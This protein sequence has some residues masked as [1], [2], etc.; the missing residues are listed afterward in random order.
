MA[1]PTGQYGKRIFPFKYL[2]CARM[3]FSCFDSESAS[4]TKLCPS[5]TISVFKAK[6]MD[7]ESSISIVTSV[8]SLALISSTLTPKAAFIWLP[9]STIFNVCEETGDRDPSS[10]AV[11]KSSAM[12]AVLL[13]VRLLFFDAF[14]L[15]KLFLYGGA[16]PRMFLLYY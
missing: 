3:L 7:P 1:C 13:N 10:S 12:F 11:L 2:V 6:R 9:T 4:S 5:L 15:L 16:L 14:L 8:T